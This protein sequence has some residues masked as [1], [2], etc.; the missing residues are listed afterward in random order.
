MIRSGFQREKPRLRKREGFAQPQHN[1]RGQQ[2]LAAS[3]L[4]KP[5]GSASLPDG[6]GSMR[7]V[8]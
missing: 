2:H 4:C 8:L 1:E 5:S 3:P 6:R 7:E